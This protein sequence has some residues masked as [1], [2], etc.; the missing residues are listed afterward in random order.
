[1]DSRALRYGSPRPSSAPCPRS[2]ACEGWGVY[3]CFSG[4]VCVH[5]VSEHRW[6]TRAMTRGE[7][8]NKFQSP[9]KGSTPGRCSPSRRPQMAPPHVPLTDPRDYD[10]F[11]PRWWRPMALRTATGCKTLLHFCWPQA[12]DRRRRG[13]KRIRAPRLASRF[14]TAGRWVRVWGR[15]NGIGVEIT[16]HPS[17]CLR[18]IKKGLGHSIL[19]PNGRRPRRCSSELQD[20]VLLGSSVGNRMKCQKSKKQQA[21]ERNR[22]RIN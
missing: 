8:S 6:M 21:A 14:D 2:V 4:C 20:E 19:D 16:H 3:L 7:C 5:A 10:R 1:M 13:A 9:Q 12:T 11:Q 18:E 17:E 22:R 15:V